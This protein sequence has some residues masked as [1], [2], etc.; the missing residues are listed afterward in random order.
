MNFNIE[1]LKAI[2]KDRPMEDIQAEEY[3]KRNR[4]WLRLSQNIALSIRFC[5]RQKGTTQKELAN[6]I[7]VSPS[8]IAKLLKGQENL[9]LETISAL[10]E[11][12]G[13]ELINIPVPYSFND[14]ETSSTNLAAVSEAQNAYSKKQRPSSPKNS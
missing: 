11:S 14:V 8:Y 10:Q 5:L 4:K 3:R 12:L 7:G 1:K 6:S 9:T 2:A 13:L